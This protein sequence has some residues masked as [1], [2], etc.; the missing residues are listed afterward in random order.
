MKRI[1]REREKV[2]FQNKKIKQENLFFFFFLQ[3]NYSML[4]VTPLK[5]ILVDCTEVSAS[6]NEEGIQGMKV[7]EK[8]NLI[9]NLKRFEEY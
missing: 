7:I 9:F 8:V 3:P 5:A 6:F 4:H 2:S 1:E